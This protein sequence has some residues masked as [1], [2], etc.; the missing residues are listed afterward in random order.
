MI[1]TVMVSLKINESVKTRILEYYEELKKV[2]FI[3][4]PEMYKILPL[5]LLESIKEFQIY[6]TVRK[7]TFIN[8]Q[9]QTQ[10]FKLVKNM[11]TYF[12]LSGDVILKQGN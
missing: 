5:S 11:Q 1:N 3:Q 10:I 12:Y 7:L 8:Q 9:S 6:T 2:N 4:S